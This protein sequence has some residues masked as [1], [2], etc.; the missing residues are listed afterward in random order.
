[1]GVRQMDQMLA[2][3]LSSYVTWDKLLIFSDT[4]CLYVENED[5]SF[6][7][8]RWCWC[9][10][11]DINEKSLVLLLILRQGSNIIS[12]H[13]AFWGGKY[14]SILTYFCHPVW[15]EMLI[16]WGNFGLFRFNILLYC[17]TVFEFFF[18]HPQGLLKEV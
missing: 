5:I 13:L 7:L 4:H 17:F 16:L 3:V 1:M 11:N 10:L 8:G 15:T 6:N 18:I 2:W 14:T 12:Y 9:G